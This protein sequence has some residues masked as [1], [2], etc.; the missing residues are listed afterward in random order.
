MI[1]PFSQVTE[2]TRSPETL[3]SSLQFGQITF[4]VELEPTGASVSTLTMIPHPA[5]GHLV[6]AVIIGAHDIP[7][8]PS[9]ESV[10]LLI[11]AVLLATVQRPAH[12]PVLSPIES[13]GTLARRSPVS[14]RFEIG[15]IGEA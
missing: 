8:T 12:S 13:A 10:K 11:N 15:V 1:W 3:C 5:Q 14:S 9:N 2:R 6:M 4:T 7:N